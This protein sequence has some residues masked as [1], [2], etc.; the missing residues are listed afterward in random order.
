MSGD[1][2][3]LNTT[4]DSSSSPAFVRSSSRTGTTTGVPSAAAT[5][6]ASSST[7]T[8][9]TAT[10]LRPR[11][12]RILSFVEDEGAGLGDVDG[13]GGSDPAA[14][15]VAAGLLGSKRGGGGG[16]PAPYAVT[17]S[18]NAQRRFAARTAPGPAG[19]DASRRAP[20]A[21]FAADLL[22]SSWSSIQGFASAVMGGADGSSPL[23]N[24]A[25]VNGYR[26][27][28]GLGSE[29]FSR[30][31][32]GGRVRPGLPSAWG[33]SS[34]SAAAQVVPGSKEER[35]AILQSKKRE[36]LMQVNGDSIP[37]T[38]SNYKRRSSLEDPCCSAVGAPVEQDDGDALVYIHQVQPNDSLTSV[39]IR[40]GCPLP[41]VR[42][43]NGFW[44]SDSIQSRK[45]VVLPVASC[46]IKGRRIPSNRDLNQSAL[47][48]GTAAVDDH[49]DDSSS[50]MPSASS[51]AP[52]GRGDFVSEPD[53][54]F[55]P[56]KSDKRSDPTPLWIHESWVNVQGH[57]SPVELGRVPKRTLGFF[58]RARR[59]S[60][61]HSDA[62]SDLDSSSPGRM[63]LGS[64]HSPQTSHFR[65]RSVSRSKHASPYRHPPRHGIFLSGPGGV[66][67][68][69]RNVTGPGP[70]P[71]KL[72]A[73]VSTHLPNLAI[74]PPPTD[75]H[76]E[77]LY[78]DSASNA[79]TAHS[80]IGIENIG[81]AIEGWFRKVATKAKVG[82]N[83]FQQPAQPHGYLGIGGN[84]DLIEMD[85]TSDSGPTGTLKVSEQTRGRMK[86]SSSD[87]LNGWGNHST[88]GRNIARS[89]D[90]SRAKDD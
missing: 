28:P 48:R 1:G 44:P 9:T 90:I 77:S 46:S 89:R 86:T 34:S 23:K 53:D 88:R 76:N 80:N 52:F 61:G 82:L 2:N 39:S 27:A 31:R 17:G 21:G 19:N 59:K 11:N 30:F 49:V 73:F 12:R 70:A 25:P 60:Q 65:D 56:S 32:D 20:A 26:R 18:S 69:D 24:K 79:S 55:S 43:S 47:S 57:S 62:Y 78:S 67:T 10:A 4:L 45:I 38:Q 5:A 7:S 71:D 58:P 81:G 83:D 16:G 37:D 29:P 85:E 50:L 33:P 15:S 72:N 84:G 54:P 41:V 3:I 35:H 87:V 8:T 36:M 74:P 14:A 40:Y 51:T 64:I 75:A 22:G 6:A 42:K 13:L 68:L 66:G 63:A